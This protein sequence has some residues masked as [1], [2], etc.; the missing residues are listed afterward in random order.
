MTRLLLVAC[1]SI[2]EALCVR[3]EANVACRREARIS[4]GSEQ[5]RASLRQRG[6][7]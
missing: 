4:A 6:P 3:P 2:S 7:T 1:C 5:A